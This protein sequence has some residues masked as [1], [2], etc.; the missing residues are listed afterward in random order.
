MWGPFNAVCMGS[1]HNI[2]KKNFF[3]TRVG[4]HSRSKK[5]LKQ[6]HDIKTIKSLIVHFPFGMTGMDSRVLIALMHYPSFS[7]L[8]WSQK[9]LI[10]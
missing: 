9:F 2:S 7:T 8:L 5:V 1:G 4:D 6:V 3:L 10:V